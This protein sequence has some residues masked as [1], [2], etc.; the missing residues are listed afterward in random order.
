MKPSFARSSVFRSVPPFVCSSVPTR[1]GCSVRLSVAGFV[2][3][4]DG[5][6][7]CARTKTTSKYVEQRRIVD[8]ASQS[9]DPVSL[10]CYS[11]SVRE[12][13]QTHFHCWTTYVLSG[14]FPELRSIFVASHLPRER[15]G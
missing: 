14:V 4:T 9:P 12:F 8:V 7:C 2:R 6:R 3:R 5:S 13:E 1:D 10:V 11:F 15:F